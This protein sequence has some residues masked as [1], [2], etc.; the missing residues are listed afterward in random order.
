LLLPEVAC[1]DIVQSLTRE[2]SAI[3]APHPSY[4]EGRLEA[5]LARLAAER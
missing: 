3:A 4:P 2:A 5:M 1:G